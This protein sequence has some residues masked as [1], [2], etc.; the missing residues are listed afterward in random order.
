MQS[1]KPTLL[2]LRKSLSINHDFPYF[3]TRLQTP[4]RKF[5]KDILHAKYWKS[6]LLHNKHNTTNISFTFFAMGSFLR[7]LSTALSA[8]PSVH[9]WAEEWKPFCPVFFTLRWVK[10]GA[11][12]LESNLI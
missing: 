4:L 11:T 2:T 3:Y 12:P 10:I 7:R 1:K 6:C 9:C 5:W 8:F